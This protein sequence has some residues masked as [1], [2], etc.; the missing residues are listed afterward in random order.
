MKNNKSQLSALTPQG[1]LSSIT[2]YI[3]VAFPNYSQIYPTFICC[4]ETEQIPI[5]GRFRAP[6][7]VHAFAADMRLACVATEA[8][9]AVFFSEVWEYTIETESLSQPLSNPAN[10]QNRQEGVIIV[11]QTAGAETLIKEMPTVTAA[12]GKRHLVQGM[13]QSGTGAQ[14]IFMEMLPMSPPSFVDQ[15]DTD[16]RVGENQPEGLPFYIYTEGCFL[17]ASLK[18]YWRRAKKLPCMKPRKT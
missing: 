9:R 1:A 10:H 8:T 7:D 6:E 13:V 18:C 3:E 4:G 14:G 11:V 12:S 5:V 15:P 17:F 16:N 2:A